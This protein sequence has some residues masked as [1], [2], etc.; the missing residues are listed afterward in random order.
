MALAAVLALLL[1]AVH[2]I[3]LLANLSESV[4]YKSQGSAG[5][6]FYELGTLFNPNSELFL[7]PLLFALALSGLV[8]L[9]R[10]REGRPVL[11]LFALGL[12][13]AVRLPFL[14][15]ARSVT[16]LGGL[17]PG[18]YARSIFWMALSLAVALG[19][20]ALTEGSKSTRLLAARL[21]ALGLIAYGV[22]AWADYQSGG[23]AFLLLRKDLLVWAAV[24]GLFL[25]LAMV[26]RGRV[27]A[28]AG[29]GGAVSMLVLAPLAIQKFGF[30]LFNSLDPLREGPPA[31]AQLR[32]LP[33]MGH[34]RMVAGT[35]S[36]RERSWLEP[37][38]ATLWQVR[39]VRMVSPLFL[40]RYARLSASL[41]GSR[42]SLDTWMTF[43]DVSP[44]LLALLGVDYRAEL[45]EPSSTTFR[46]IPQEGALPRAYWVHRVLPVPGEK[47]A[48]QLV[49][50]LAPMFPKGDLSEGVIVEGWPGEVRVGRPSDAD[51]VEWIEDG[52]TWLRLRASSEAGGVFVLL[53]TFASGWKATVD[54]SAAPIYPAN[55]AFR[56]IQVPPG[57]HDIVFRYAPLAVTVGMGLTG[58]GWLGVL[59]LAGKAWR[60]RRAP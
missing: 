26:A 6:A 5:R 11:V 21:A 19:A 38:L 15:L 33:G 39:D 32:T 56:A 34:G 36:N 22:M 28:G 16:S 40:R 50:R 48:R 53:D 1:A 54:G 35:G 31:I 13:S 2:W 47:E 12:L 37:N 59:F 44:V 55:L 60:R 8:G 4:S 51:R 14:G 18:I 29:L 10:L 9:G 27:W 20:K 25:T 52:L 49:A 24:A 42:R 17:L 23:M 41:G 30:P 3:P 46:W 57:T 43:E 7:D 58:A 45:Q